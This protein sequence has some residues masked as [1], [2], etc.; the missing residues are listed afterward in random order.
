MVAALN[1]HGFRWRTG[2]DDLLLVS[3]GT[4]TY[5][6]IYSTDAIVGM[7]AAK[8]GII[9]L[10]SLMDDCGRMNHAVLQWLTNCL[11]PWKIDSAVG[12]MTLDSANGP[13]LATY[14]RYDVLL[15]PEWLATTVKVVYDAARVAKIAAMDDPT[16]M[17]DLARIGS[18][19]AAIQVK[20]E[21]FPARFDI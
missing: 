10:Q 13:K 14:A 2:A 18:L 19:A 12:D 8:E 7:V 1:G 21:H 3:A 11:T 5:K 17:E 4:G 16:N 15:E 6:Q 9:A 20:P